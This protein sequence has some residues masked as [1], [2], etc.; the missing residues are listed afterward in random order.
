[1]PRNAPH[2]TV[3][4]VVSPSILEELDR[5]AAANKVTRSTMI[6][7]LLEQ[8][9]TE[10]A[11]ERNE[12]AFDRLEKRLKRIEDRF[13]KLI[14]NCTKLAA[15]AF[16]IGMVGLQAKGPMNEEQADKQFN[17]AKQYAG[18]LVAKRLKEDIGG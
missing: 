1:M 11:K 7:D 8:K 14:I 17:K 15:Q 18:E 13:S 4:A 3:T 9:L 10:R 5:L 16:Y 2:I 6:R 12:D